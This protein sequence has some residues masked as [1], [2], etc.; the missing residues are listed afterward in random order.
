MKPGE[1]AG[2][3]NKALLSVDLSTHGKASPSKSS[4]LGP[5]DQ[6]ESHPENIQR[7]T[8]SQKVD[9]NPI[10]DVTKSRNRKRLLED[11]NKILLQLL[12]CNSNNRL[13]TIYLRLQQLQTRLNESMLTDQAVTDSKFQFRERVRGLA[14][15]LRNEAGFEAERLAQK[16]GQTCLVCNTS[17][18]VYEED[19][20]L[21]CDCCSVLVHQMCVGIDTSDLDNSPWFCA[22]C[23]FHRE[24]QSL[25]ARLKSVFAS[26][27][28]SRGASKKALQH[29][30]SLAQKTDVACVM[31]GRYGGVFFEVEGMHGEFCHASCAFWLDELSISP[32]SKKVIFLNEEDATQRLCRGHLDQ[33]TFFL[34]KKF[35]KI[36]TCLVNFFEKKKQ[37][38]KVEQLQKELVSVL[39]ESS[40]NESHSHVIKSKRKRK[41]L[42]S[43]LFEAPDSPQ[44]D[45]ECLFH[46]GYAPF[47]KSRIL[48][49]IREYLRKS[50]L[51]RKKTGS[52]LKSSAKRRGSHKWLAQVLILLNSSSFFEDFLQRTSWEQPE[53]HGHCGEC[54]HKRGSGCRICGETRGLLVKCYHSGCRHHLHVECGRRVECELGFPLKNLSNE[55]VHSVF[56]DIHSKSPGERTRENFQKIKEREIGSAERKI[57]AKWGKMLRKRAREE[58]IESENV[59]L[60]RGRGR[61]AGGR[62]LLIKKR[63]DSRFKFSIMKK[64][65]WSFARNTF[66]A[67]NS[68]LKQK[69]IIWDLTLNP[70]KRREKEQGRASGVEKELALEGDS[71]LSFMD[72]KKAEK[73]SNV[74][75]QMDPASTRKKYSLKRIRLTNF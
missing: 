58:P 72:Q 70:Q 1:G 75:C 42:Q 31:C 19:V 9:T 17:N 11:T 55:M 53:R 8:K 52:T 44:D 16:K 66:A 13:N 39:S 51:N 37:F 14:K 10:D 68:I 60:N 33:N 73:W 12:L 5:R 18:C 41:M 63:Q 32:R 7:E 27:A 50:G 35:C 59:D 24:N 54:G 64:P 62:R 47:I 74:A 43:S 65:D 36:E 20:L 29:L 56:C 61:R 22:T 15:R 34:N 45:C 25:V 38:G 49:W 40:D 23:Q 30:D 4:L 21:Y 46:S 3:S 67:K 26:G 69:G 28:K 71:E 48:Y 2:H 6:S 57:R